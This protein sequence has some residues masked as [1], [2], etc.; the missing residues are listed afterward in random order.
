[1]G[2]AQETRMV[3]L[4]KAFEL[5]YANGYKTTSI[6]QI[7]ATTQ[8]TKGAFF[9]HFKTKDQMG[10]AIIKDLLMPRLAENILKPL[11]TDRNPLEAIYQLIESLLTKNDFLKIEFGCPVANFTHEMSPWNT[12]F[13]KVLKDLISQ[14][15]KAMTETIENGKGKGFVRNDVD[16]G[17]VTLF[18]LS[19]YW[20][21]RNFGKLKNTKAVYKDYLIAL[22]SYLNTLQ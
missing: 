4:Q 22:K 15:T 18:V 2:K 16:A 11:Q 12:D 3:I 17:Q 10:V 6:D 19:G 21:I 14:W 1:M 8:V 13:N 5:I 20:G 7:I 9:Y